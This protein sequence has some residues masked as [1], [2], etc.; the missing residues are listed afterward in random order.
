MERV[1]LLAAVL[2]LASVVG[3]CDEEPAESNGAVDLSRQPVAA[4]DG[5]RAG[6]LDVD[7][8]HVY[9]KS[10]AVSSGEA[11]VQDRDGLLRA[12]GASTTLRR[13]GEDGPV[14][15]VDLGVLT[16]GY[17]EV[18]LADGTD[19]PVRL[20]YAE[21][22]E[23]LDPIIGD[24]SADP[25]DFFHGGQTPGTDDDPDARADVFTPPGEQAMVT[26]PGLRGSQRYVAVSLDG[27]G[28]AAIDYIR[29]RQTQRP[30]R[31]EGYFHSSDRALNEAWFASAYG[32]NLSVAKDDRRNPDAGWIVLDGP[33]RDRI[34]Y[35][36][37]LQIVAR[38][39]YYQSGDYRESVRNTIALF[40]CQQMPD[41]SFPVSSRIDVPCDPANP[42]PPDGTPPEW[43][44]SQLVTM[45]R[46]DSFTAWWVVDLADY[47]RFA[48]DPEFVEAM[49]PVARRAVEFFAAH[50]PDGV[51]FATDGYDGLHPINWHP[52]DLAPG[53]DAY[54][55]A[56]YYAAL[57]S[58][59]ELEGAVGDDAAVQRLNQ[60]ADQVRDALLAKLW[61]PEAGAMVLNSTDPRRDHTADATIGPLLFGMF[62]DEQAKQAMRFLET[63]LASQ[64][65]TK[66]SEYPDNV[67]MEQFVSPYL[68][69]NEALGRFRNGDGDG[70]LRLIRTTWGHMLRNGPGTP[71]EQ[72]LL[73]GTVGGAGTQGGST[74]LAHAW[75]TVVPPLSA[76]VLGA[77]PA[78]DGF[79]EWRV[80][81]NPVDLRWAQGDVPTP[82]GTLAVRWQREERDSSFRLTVEAPPDTT[83]TVE[84]PLLGRDRDI[85]MNGRVVWQ[86]G[87]AADAGVKAKRVGDRV[88]FTGVSGAST[89]AW[90]GSSG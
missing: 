69:A 16:S 22:K 87:R 90:A 42:G 25:A 51:L 67:Y 2:V 21:G 77:E 23:F 47:H 33:K 63:T 60:T 41:G 50:A 81:P 75:S 73:D 78:A 79:R 85:A 26:S 57:R 3:A 37:D 11:G 89:F 55:N 70:A 80:A 31:Y 40:A 28:S 27:P 66:T 19:A 39:G 24:G 59:A 4:D 43:A 62:D 74:G 32:V 1:R 18:G 14:L 76:N 6:V 44:L 54:T 5:W 36:G 7:G 84:V 56:A 15:V 46:L 30:G 53:V 68:M 64:Y 58:L 71:W 88:V 86:D 48:G 8:T 29:V 20:A 82:R 9:P 38:S 12:G 72:I 10:V 49:L 52:P 35:V 17:V 45:A 65:G 83:G 13:D 61:D 34:P